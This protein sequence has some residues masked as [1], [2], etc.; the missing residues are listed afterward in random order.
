MNHWTVEL[1]PGVV[2]HVHLHEHQQRRCWSYVTEG[3][4]AHDHSELAFSWFHEEGDVPIPPRPLEFLD[5]VCRAVGEGHRVGPGDV[6]GF[7]AGSQVF[8]REDVSGVLY[9]PCPGLEGLSLAPETLSAIPLLG[10]ELDRVG[11]QGG[12]RLMTRQAA[13]SRVFPYPVSFDRQRQL[14]AL[15][16]HES[17]LALGFPVI[18]SWMTHA[19]SEADRLTLRIPYYERDRIASALGNLAADQPFALLTGI[20]PDA[21]GLFVWFPAQSDPE[22]LAAPDVRPRRLAGNFFFFAGSAGASQG[23]WAEDGFR[24][25]LSAGDFQALRQALLRGEAFELDTRPYALS[26]ESSNHQVVLLNDETYLEQAGF[27]TE[28]TTPLLQELLGLMELALQRDGLRGLA[29]RVQIA[30][31]GDLGVMFPENLKFA[32]KNQLGLAVMEARAPS[33]RLPVQLELHCQL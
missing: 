14:E 1:L 27:D 10:E 13:R 20:A 21:D 8:G 2:V 5:T 9:V 29:M 11:Q 24:M 32:S 25:S 31:S 6:T 4:R 28:K 26:I 30:P 19:W 7:A 22:L 33:L 18:H 17:V 15:D 3:L 23:G 12:A 16:E